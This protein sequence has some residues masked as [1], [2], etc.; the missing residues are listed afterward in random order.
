MINCRQI[1][2]GN[3]IVWRVLS[4]SELE[5]KHERR[6]SRM[7]RPKLTEGGGEDQHENPMCKFCPLLWMEVVFGTWQG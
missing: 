3:N 1:S 4:S 7:F 2:K 5:K 6:R